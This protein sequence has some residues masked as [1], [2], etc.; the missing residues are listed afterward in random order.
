[1]ADRLPQWALWT[2]LTVFVVAMALITRPLLPVDETRYLAVAW[3][4]WLRGDFLVPHLNGAT[5]S[6]KP[7][8]LFWLINAGWWAFGVN[9]WTPRLVAPLFALGSLFL[10][11]RV[12]R[13]LWPDDHRAAAYA[14]WLLFG[15]GFWT[16]FTTLTMFDIILAFFAVAGISGILTAWRGQRLKGFAVLALA[17][18]FGVLAKGPAILLHLLPVAL[19]VPWWGGRGPENGGSG[20]RS[21]LLW[22]AGILGAVVAGAVIALAWAVPAGIAGGEAYRDAIFWGQS[23]G[24]MVESF[25][26]RRAWWWYLA[27]FPGLI[28]PWILWPGLWRA[29]GQGIR[30]TGQDL[31]QR[32]CAIW[33]VVAFAVFSMISGKQLHYQLP[34][35][36]VVA[37][38][39]A[40]W[41]SNSRSADRSTPLDRLLIGGLGA[42]LGLVMIAAEIVAL[43]V[44]LPWRLPAWFPLLEGGWGVMPLAAGLWILLRGWP[45]AE[46]GLPLVALLPVVT[47][48]AV[49]LAAAPV[50]NSVYDLRPIARHLKELEN[51][52]AALANFGKYHGQYHFL[53]RLEKPIAVMGVVQDDQE[54]FLK[55]HP[56]G[57]IVAYYD[58]LPDQADP[59]A[60]Y[61]FRQRTV[62]IW[63]AQT[64]ID[65]PGIGDRR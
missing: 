16:L 28:L 43:I 8:L 12:A 47:V 23:A 40:R 5:Y 15:C 13:Q 1:V 6:H 55:A 29:A 64:M 35:F 3:E 54:R 18:G 25:A 17:V 50:L 44:A 31:G 9:E 61:I 45:N 21:W 24:R 46:R 49:H 2:A 14:P 53:G 48:V 19:S 22:Y 10:T 56:N 60:T 39:L 38:L 7:P 42:M 34:E 36:P 52:G 59:V 57:R 63:T 20:R 32:L 58:N 30:R 37:L 26:H 62:A 4:M 27:V 51:A 65:H 11:V 41:L 33:F